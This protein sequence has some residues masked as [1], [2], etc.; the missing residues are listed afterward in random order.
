MNLIRR[1]AMWLVWHGPRLPGDWAPRLFA[2][3]LNA[4]FCRVD[5]TDE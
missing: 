1:I 3:G 2:F 4:P 5:D